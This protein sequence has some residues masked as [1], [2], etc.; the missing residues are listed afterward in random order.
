MNHSCKE[1]EDRMR[2]TLIPVFLFLF[3]FSAAMTWAG[4]GDQ[5][6]PFSAVKMDPEVVQAVA[7]EG[8]DIYVEVSPSYWN[9]EFIV[10]ISNDYMT[11][12]RQWLD[13]EW[14]MPVRVYQSQ[15]RNKQ[16]YT[17]RINTAAP[18]VE[19]WTGGKLV[20]ILERLQ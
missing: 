10:K 15:K 18:F 12:Y 4:E 17:Y 6:G 19:Y 8:N 1:V 11:S 7:V 3:C 20:L 16:G 5:Y 13:G 14:E 9:E 2:K